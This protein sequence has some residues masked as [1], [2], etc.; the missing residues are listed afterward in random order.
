VA[1]SQT[2][3]F[4]DQLRPFCLKVRVDLPQIMDFKVVANIDLETLRFY[5]EESSGLPA[6]RVQGQ[7]KCTSHYGRRY[8]QDLS[9]DV[10][11]LPEESLILAESHWQRSTEMIHSECCCRADRRERTPSH[12]AERMI[13]AMREAQAWRGWRYGHDNDSGG[14]KIKSQNGRIMRSNTLVLLRCV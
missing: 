1:E 2:V 7:H 10:A 9:G 13:P 11:A 3:G 6:L 8:R 12:L 4:R 5:L 14:A